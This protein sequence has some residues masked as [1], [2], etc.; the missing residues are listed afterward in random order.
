MWNFYG[1]RGSRTTR[2]PNIP[3]YHRITNSEVDAGNI[4]P[5]LKSDRSSNKTDCP[6]IHT[7]THSQSYKI[8]KDLSKVITS[9][10]I[11]V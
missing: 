3:I 7:L 1:E 8:G 2:L 11:H 10:L 6:T 9:N 4:V 5:L